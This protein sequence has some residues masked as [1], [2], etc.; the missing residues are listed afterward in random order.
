MRHPVIRHAARLAALGLA[1]AAALPGLAG[2]LAAGSPPVDNLAGPG[3]P[4]LGLLG[5]LR[6]RD[7]VAA[8]QP[9]GPAVRYRY[10]CPDYNMV[11]GSLAEYFTR[12]D[13]AAYADFC[14]RLNLD[15]AL[16]L[17][18]PTEGYCTY[19][20]RVGQPFPHLPGDWFGR[21]VAELHR[22][23][24]AAFAYV[25]LGWN[26]KYAREHPECMSGGTLCFNSPYA[27]LVLGYHRE[28]LKNYP[29]DGIRNDIYWQDLKCHC[30]GCR[31]FYRELFGE[32]LPAQWADRDWRRKEEFRRATLARIVQRISA[33]GKA[34]KPSVPLWENQLN[35]HY[36]S[37]L[38]ALRYVDAVYMEYGEPFGLLFHR[39]VNPD[40]PV[41]VGKLE[42]LP[43]QQMRLCMA[44]G[45][46]GYTYIKALP[47]TA[48]PPATEAE[49][50]AFRR[51]N[52][53]LTGLARAN[54]RSQ[55]EVERLLGGFYRMIA[56]I[57]PYLV[58]TR[59]V[60]HG[61]GVVFCEATRYRY[62]GFDRT[63]YSKGV[64]QPLA[65]AYLARSVPLEFVDS[66]RLPDDDLS[67]FRLLVLPETSGLTEPEV[68]ALRRY[69]RR[70]GQLLLA[71]Q[72]L[73]HDARGL[74]LPDFALAAEMGLSLTNRP[75]P[76][77]HE[78][79]CGRGK[80]IYRAAPFST[81]DLV[82][83]MDALAPACPVTVES[84]ER[85]EGRISEAEKAS[86]G[87][88][89]RIAGSYQ[90][91]GGLVPPGPELR[92]PARQAGR[93]RKFGYA[94][95][96]KNQVILTYQIFRKRYI[97]HLLSDGDY[98]V[99][100][101]KEYAPVRRIAGQYPAAGWSAALEPTAAGARIRV[102]GTA[103]NRLLVLE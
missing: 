59:P 61:A 24:I 55:P 47:T 23:G 18:V 62:R 68:Q 73:C 81:A 98:A 13:P 3:V 79:P 21:T 85:A 40:K 67:R 35:I 44:L 63:P 70:G 16:L 90:A 22:R 88:D 2:G 50:E 26:Y 37:P 78:Q 75:L 12:A 91:P 89:G 76:K 42:S 71:G 15:A 52:N 39:G 31:A 80:I 96:A 95:G 33:A 60:F 8:Y 30:Q 53:W 92:T 66:A 7:P 34:V 94:P 27:D 11:G 72:A 4:P 5:W 38:E 69:V 49:A 6:A 25:T 100:I 74:P 32:E 101:R 10:L 54:A 84:A 102:Q 14:Q 17:A 46:R 41:I 83:E 19:P 64:L 45:A 103:G 77:R 86:G 93:E 9:Q 1:W 99:G 58:G 43:P 82:Q 65:E 87:T 36:N 57:Q 51:R 48:L 28:I 97:L 20:T 56:E 29:V